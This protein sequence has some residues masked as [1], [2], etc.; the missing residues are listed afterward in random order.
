VVAASL[1]KKEVPNWSGAIKPASIKDIPKI[2]SIAKKHK[3]PFLPTNGG[4]GPKIGLSK[5]KGVNINLSGLNTVKVDKA[6][7][8][9]T[10]G[11]GATLGEV[12]EALFAAGKE[13]RMCT[14]LSRPSYFAYHFY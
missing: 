4:H 10:V 1:K 5:F 9:V 11:P 2:I 3:I 14:I 13:L 7:N 6:R 12:A 8:R